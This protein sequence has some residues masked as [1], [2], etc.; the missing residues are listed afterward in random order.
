LS[1]SLP[2]DFRYTPIDSRR[3]TWRT[4]AEVSSEGRVEVRVE[5]YGLPPGSVPKAPETPP[6]ENPGWS[7]VARLDVPE[8]S[9]AVVADVL[10]PREPASRRRRT[11][12]LF[13]P[14]RLID[15]EFTAASEWFSSSAFDTIVRSLR[16]DPSV[17]CEE[18]PASGEREP[19]HRPEG[20]PATVSSAERTVLAI[21]ERRSRIAAGPGHA[22]ATTTAE[23]RAE[24]TPSGRPAAQTAA[25]LAKPTATARPTR[26]PTT[27]APSASPRAAAAP[28]ARAA[29]SPS[30]DPARALRKAV[31]SAVEEFVRGLRRGE[32]DRVLAVLSSTIDP[33]RDL[34][35]EA[36]Q[37]ASGLVRPAGGMNALRVTHAKA[38]ET[39]Y[40]LSAEARLDWPNDWQPSGVAELETGLLSIRSGDAV[41]LRL[42]LTLRREGG[43][44]KVAHAA[45]T[46]PGRERE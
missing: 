12:R 24:R 23:D 31:A 20:T 38:P 16:V 1:I 35:T 33:G 8:R 27:P 43:A 40:D 18:V 19:S 32:R 36:F 21:G 9:K 37:A 17:G 45:F 44:W 11:V 34:P 25:P 7:V 2:Q 6:S 14:C 13:T 10:R 5:D 42:D 22:I 4:T 3:G 30:P 29:A 28:E 15:L 39:A 46:V 26:E 41:A